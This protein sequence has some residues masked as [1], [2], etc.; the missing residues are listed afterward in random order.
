M[1]NKKITFLILVFILLVK[2]AS[3]MQKNF[4]LFYKGTQGSK[5][6]IYFYECMEGK[7]QSLQQLL[8][9]YKN[10][11]KKNSLNTKDFDACFKNYIENIVLLRDQYKDQLSDIP[12]EKVEKRKC[13]DAK[14][15]Y[16]KKALQLFKG[17]FK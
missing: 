5:L 10:L 15:L 14:C 16:A 1:M 17:Y 4:D 6:S 2:N 3:A 12:K 13:I 9:K 8:E 11:H 7:T